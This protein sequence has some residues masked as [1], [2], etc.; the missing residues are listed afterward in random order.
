MLTKVSKFSN[1]NFILQ[2]FQTS[3]FPLIFI[4]KD[5]KNS[6]LPCNTNEVASESCSVLGSDNNFVKTVTVMKKCI[7]VDKFCM[8]HCLLCANTG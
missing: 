2:M 6:P 5:Q 1:L 7:N 8:K 4:N 3:Y